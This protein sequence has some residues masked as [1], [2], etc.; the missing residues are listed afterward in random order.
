MS[1]RKGSVSSIS[2]TLYLHIGF[3]PD[4]SVAVAYWYKN[5]KMVKRRPNFIWCHWHKSKIHL[6]M[7]EEEALDLLHDYRIYKNTGRPE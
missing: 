4:Q 2:K 7:T 1:W 6:D 5:G 3:D